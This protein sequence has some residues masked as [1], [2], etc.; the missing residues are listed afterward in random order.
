MNEFFSFKPSRYLANIGT[1]LINCFVW[2]QIGNLTSKNYFLKYLKNQGTV[3]VSL[4][5][6]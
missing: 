3:I 4:S 6:L 1:G 2:C 5:C